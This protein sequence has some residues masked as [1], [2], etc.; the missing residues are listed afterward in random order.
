MEYKR[1]NISNPLTMVYLPP[2]PIVFWPPSCGIPHH[3]LFETVR[4]VHLLWN[5]D[6]LVWKC[7]S[8]TFAMVLFTH[9][10]VILNPLSE[11]VSQ[12]QLLWCIEASTHGILSSLPN[13]YQTHGTLLPGKYL[14]LTCFKLWVMQNRYEILSLQQ[15]I[16]LPTHGIW[17]PLPLVFWPHS[18][19]HEL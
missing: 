2:L 5:I 18:L 9:F 3:L 19:T 4:Q 6:P 1:C 11:I 13:I 15:H 14:I 10:Y 17:N 7:E 16:E 12:V 8:S